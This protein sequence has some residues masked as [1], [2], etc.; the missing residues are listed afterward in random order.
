MARPTNAQIRINRL[1]DITSSELK[2]IGLKD[3]STS[4]LLNNAITLSLKTKGNC[5]ILDDLIK[6]LQERRETID[7]I[8]PEAYL[9]GLVSLLTKGADQRN[10]SEKSLQE[11]MG[12]PGVGKIRRV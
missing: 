10:D 1:I 6:E 3:I 12:D 2:N 9:T 8:S 11:L 7:D 4:I 5:D